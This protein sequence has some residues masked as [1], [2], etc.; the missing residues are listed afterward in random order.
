MLFK[1]LNKG[2][3]DE[4]GDLINFIWRQEVYQKN[5]SELQK[6]EFQQMILE[7]WKYLV[8][9]YEKSTNEEEEKI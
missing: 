9:K 4:V 1:F 2:T 6:Q 3:P 8:D 7:L 5:L